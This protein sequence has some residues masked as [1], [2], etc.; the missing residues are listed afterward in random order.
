MSTQYDI[1]D[2]IYDVQN[3]LEVSRC[4]IKNLWFSNNARRELG[5]LA[6]RGVRQRPVFFVHGLLENV[7]EW[8]HLL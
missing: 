1:V 8:W 5:P 4:P 2:K 6:T 7:V 3:M